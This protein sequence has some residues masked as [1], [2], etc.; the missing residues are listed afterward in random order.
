[1]SAENDFYF[2]EFAK[3]VAKKGKNKRLRLLLVFAY[4]LF[5]LLYVTAF[6]VL[7]MLPQVI[8]LLPLLLWIA[9]YFTWGL[10]SYECAVRVSSGKLSFLKL[11]GKKEACLLSLAVKDAS[12]IAPYAE[13]HLSFLRERGATIVLDHRS[14]PDTRLAYYALFEKEGKTCAVIFDAEEKVIHSLYY[15]NKNTVRDKKFIIS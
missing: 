1:M 11:R 13:E 14:D 8:A 12:V 4:F 6:T 10:V 7:I 9:V 3:P 5:A 2:A 15:Y